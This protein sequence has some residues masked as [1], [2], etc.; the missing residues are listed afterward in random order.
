MTG[1]MLSSGCRGDVPA[2]VENEARGR[3]TKPTC[4]S[5]T[6]SCILPYT[7][8]DFLKAIFV[9][10]SYKITQIWFLSAEVCCAQLFLSD[11]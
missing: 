7:A 11:K 5:Y 8:E 1:S 10:N 9:S 6:F 2:S 4:L 3:I